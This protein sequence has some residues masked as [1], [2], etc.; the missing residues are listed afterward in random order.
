MNLT[1][2]EL[3]KCIEG[4]PLDSEVEICVVETDW[5]LE[6]A[7]H[8]TWIDD[9][10]IMTLYGGKVEREDWSK[11]PEKEHLLFNGNATELGGDWG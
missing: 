6:P 7:T 5:M 2:A 9:L 1:V 8:V 4:K 11:G 3:L 10:K